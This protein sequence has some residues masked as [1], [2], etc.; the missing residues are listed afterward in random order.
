MLVLPDADLDQATHA[1][2]GA[3]YSLAGEGFMACQSRRN[4][5]TPA[6]RKAPVPLCG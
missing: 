1:L 2:M 4:S 5:E 6:I 3:A